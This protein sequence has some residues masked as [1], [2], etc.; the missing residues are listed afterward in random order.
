[1]AYSLST[2]KVK[3]TMGSISFTQGLPPC[4]DQYVLQ[5][6]TNIWLDTSTEMWFHTS[7]RIWFGMIW[8]LEGEFKNKTLF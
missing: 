8:Q 4:Q 7:T 3:S 5:Y 6:H 1:M 2:Q